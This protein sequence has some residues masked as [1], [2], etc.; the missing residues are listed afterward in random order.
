MIKAK[1]HSD[2][3]NIE[4]EFDATNWFLIA[5]DTEIIELMNCGWGGDEVADEI[6]R[7]LAASNEELSKLFDYL[8]IIFNDRSKKD[9]CGFECNVDKESALIWLRQNR[10]NLAAKYD[11]EFGD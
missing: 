1:A 10:P 7:V 9:L 6:A 8:D 5:S 3:Y 2:D 11:I 4:V